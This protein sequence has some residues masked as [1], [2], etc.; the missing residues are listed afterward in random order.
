MSGAPGMALAALWG[1]LLL[2]AFIGWGALAER[3]AMPHRGADLG[4]LAAW[5]LAIAT[6]LGGILDGAHLVS[7]GS[8][9]LFVTAGVVAAVVR[10]RQTKVAS[11][12]ET[13]DTPALSPPRRWTRDRTFLVVTGV[14]LALFVLNVAG[15]L[16]SPNGFV[17]NQVRGLNWVDDFQGYLHY[18]WKMI[19][20]GSMGAEPY[21]FRRLSFLGG[22]VFLGALVLGALPLSAVHLIDPGIATAI[23][24]LLVIGAA[25]RL[26]LSRFDQALV[27]LIV[28]MIP[29]LSSNVSAFLTGTVLFVA[30]AFSV[31]ALDRLNVQAYR[32]AGLLAILVAAGCGLKASFIPYFAMLVAADYGGRLWRTGQWKDAAREGGLLVVVTVLLLLPWMIGMHRASGTF[33]Y[34]LLGRG[35]GPP[36]S[37]YSLGTL[38]SAVSELVSLVSNRTILPLWAAGGIVLAA[39]LYRPRLGARTMAPSMWGASIAASVVVAFAL[40]GSYLSRYVLPFVIATFVVSLV[41]ALD[42]ARTSFD[43][44][45]RAR[46]VA[47][48]LGLSGIAV[49]V[50][51]ADSRKFLTSSVHA[52]A[53]GLHGPQR[54]V[55]EDVQRR[56]LALQGRT[57]IGVPILARVWTPFAFDVRRNEILTIDWPGTAGPPPGFPEQPAE[58]AAYLTRHGIRFL[59]YAIAPHPGV[60]Q[61]FR[62]LAGPVGDP[63]EREFMRRSRVFDDAVRELALSRRRLYDDG[64]LLLLDLADSVPGQPAVPLPESPVPSG[65]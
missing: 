31:T 39:N 19:E 35:V 59:A 9:R 62:D 56:I 41:E 4:L 16:Y 37:P 22:Q 18:T 34:P 6:I 15:A 20:T 38:G 32:R 64:V 40:G 51:F 36:A 5:G 65:E 27:A 17:A 2:I 44:A 61:S 7:R 43:P 10:F 58:V 57:P 30:Y 47:L 21:S 8:V 13:S 29:P 23:L 14:A 52:V 28:L 54:L 3:V 11:A 25:R 53:A 46:I 49:G 26:D 63:A 45:E 33:L 48:A 12:A 55:P 60:T 24:L 42:A 50:R 1:A